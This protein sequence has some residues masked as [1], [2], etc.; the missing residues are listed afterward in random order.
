MGLPHYFIQNRTNRGS[1]LV[2][3]NLSKNG[4]RS[5]Y[6]TVSLGVYDTVLEDVFV[7]GIFTLV[8]TI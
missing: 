1:Q 2:D 4:L 5:V 7:Y 8:E 3:T 6:N